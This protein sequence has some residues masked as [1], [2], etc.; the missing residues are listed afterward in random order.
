E[1]HRTDTSDLPEHGLN[2]PHRLLTGSGGSGG[3]IGIG[4]DDLAAGDRPEGE[5]CDGVDRVLD[6]PDR[7]VAERDIDATGV[8]APG[9]GVGAGLEAE[10]VAIDADFHGPGKNQ[11]FGPERAE[12]SE[13]TRLGGG[14]TLIVFRPLGANINAELPVDEWAAAVVIR[15]ATP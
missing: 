9:G 6:E 2:L 1:D 8:V 11:R 15:T 10:R 3:S 14:E 5:P 7:S 4:A 12:N 13:K